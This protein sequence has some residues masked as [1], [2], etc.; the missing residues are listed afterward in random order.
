MERLAFL[1]IIL[2]ECARYIIWGI[3]R[4]ATSAPYGRTHGAPIAGEEGMREGIPWAVIWVR[5]RSFTE[6]G[7]CLKL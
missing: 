7:N 4:R 2:V 6:R 3:F 1:T 5:A